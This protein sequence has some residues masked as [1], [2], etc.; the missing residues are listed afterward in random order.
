MEMVVPGT[1]MHV[2]IGAAGLALLR[3]VVSGGALLTPGPHTIVAWSSA[4]NFA[5]ACYRLYN[6]MQTLDLDDGEFCTYLAVSSSETPEFRAQ[7]L[8]PTAETV[9]QTLK[10]RGTDWCGLRCRFHSRAHKPFDGSTVSEMLT[11]LVGKKV[12]T[13]KS[14]AE[15]WVA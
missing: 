7:G 14:A 9:A 12:V 3:M 5:D 8:Y 6:S 13:R 10:D 1:K 4:A 11:Y 15:W 2:Q